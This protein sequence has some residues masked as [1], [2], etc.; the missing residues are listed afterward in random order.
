L[1]WGFE[2]TTN[3]R[4]YQ[5]ERNEQRTRTTKPCFHPSEQLEQQ[6]NI[7]NIEEMEKVFLN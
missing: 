4:M 6:P 7:I 2:T 5:R 3:N 1:V